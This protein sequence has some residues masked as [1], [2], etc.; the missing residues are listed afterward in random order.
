MKY[1]LWISDFSEGEWNE[2]KENM[3][4][5]REQRPLPCRCVCTCYVFLLRM[6][7]SFAFLFF[8]IK[9]FQV[10]WG[11]MSSVKDIISTK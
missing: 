10:G 3:K 8:W 4:K 1:I 11:E 5:E 2:M 7:S 6:V 9:N